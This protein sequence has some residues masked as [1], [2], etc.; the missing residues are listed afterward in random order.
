MVYGNR[1]PLVRLTF[2]A[3][4]LVVWVATGFGRWGR[5][6]VVTLCYHGIRPDQVAR[7]RRQMTAIAPRSIA[8]AQIG[9][10]PHRF[11]SAPRVCVTFDDAFANL[12]ENALPVTRGLHI[13]VTVFAVTGSLGTR[14]RWL[15]H[16][17]HPDAVEITMTPDQ[18]AEAARDPLCTIGSHTDTHRNLTRLGPEEVRDELVR[19]RE[20][21][22][23]LLRRRV[24]DFAFP[25]GAANPGVIGE[26]LAAG[27]RRVFTLNQPSNAA[28]PDGSV[29]CRMIM[30][31]DIW[32]IEFRLT[33]AGAYSWL[34]P[35]KG[36]LRPA[37]GRS[38]VA[39]EGAG[40]AA[41]DRAGSTKPSS[42][43]V[44]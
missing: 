17:D 1:G 22:E 11:G 38:R 23:S 44:R 21:L 33:A 20:G 10:T 8:A 42:T 41:A 7:F 29:V 26:A 31:P 16:A 6:A 40:A 19:S 12:I 32:P 35:L 3:V 39:R 18:I 2:L 34:T 43:T 36:W 28:A 13:P 4:S 27:Y 37:Q 30:S 9:S 25:Y 15:T 14:P 5:T 24:E